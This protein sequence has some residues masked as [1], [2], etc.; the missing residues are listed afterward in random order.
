MTTTIT[1]EA[2]TSRNIGLITEKEQRRL[3]GSVVAVLGMGGIGGVVAE[4]LARAGV[5]RLKIVD[6]D[7][8]EVSNLNRQIFAYAHTVGRKKTEV[9][10]EFL[11]GINPGLKVDVYDTVSEDNADDVVSGADAIVLGID[12]VAPCIAAM[13][14][15]RARGIP[16][17]RV[18]HTLW[19]CPRYRLGNSVS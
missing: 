3:R 7:V 12:T 11:L 8:F 17:W 15:A 18:G 6:R 9:A 4:L 13:R 10:R 14:A 1:Y 19:K 16:R 5:G 2:M